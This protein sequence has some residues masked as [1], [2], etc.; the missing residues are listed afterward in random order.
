[1]MEVP[2]P[3]ASTGSQPKYSL[4]GYIDASDMENLDALLDDSWEKI[5][6][7]PVVEMN[8]NSSG[9]STSSD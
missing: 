1:M 7:R 6:V 5:D 4:V 3:I 2:Q 9:N 8:V